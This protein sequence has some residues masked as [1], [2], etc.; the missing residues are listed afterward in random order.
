[1]CEIGKLIKRWIRKFYMDQKAAT[2]WLSKVGNPMAGRNM[3]TDILIVSSQ[4]GGLVIERFP[5]RTQ[6]FHFLSVS[7]VCSQFFMFIRGRPNVDE[8][9]D[10][11]DNYALLIGTNLV[12]IPL[13]VVA[14]YG[15]M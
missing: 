14:R 7:L 5:V 13:P 10:E 12:P 4:L 1:M 2:K 9:S 3:K 8:I 15:S 11:L 6:N